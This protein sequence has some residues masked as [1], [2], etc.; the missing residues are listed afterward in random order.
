M[1]DSLKDTID[2]PSTTAG[3]VKESA[4]PPVMKIPPRPLQC[5]L[6]SF[7]DTPEMA[8]RPVPI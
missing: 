6:N 3:L 5:G 1:A 8:K 7:S 4:S 2:P